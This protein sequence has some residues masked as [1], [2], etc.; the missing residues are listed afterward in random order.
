MKTENNEYKNFRE[1]I[2][3]SKDELASYIDNRITLL[4]LTAY[5][6]VASSFSYIIYGLIIAVFLLV[7]CLFLLIGSGLSLGEYLDNYALGFGILGAGVLI[8]LIIIILCRKALR[9]FLINHT[10][11]TIKKIESDEN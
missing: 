6:K 10:L 9:K 3:E 1:I 4:K 5:E 2:D 7:L 11:R 8:I